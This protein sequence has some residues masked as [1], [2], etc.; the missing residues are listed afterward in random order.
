MDTLQR[1]NIKSIGELWE[2]SRVALQDIAAPAGLSLDD[3][4][5]DLSN[6]IIIIGLVLFLIFAHRRLLSGTICTFQA[7][8]GTKRL[9][10]IESQSNLQVCR[11]TLFQFLTVCTSF[12]FANIAYATGIIGHTH[13]LPV[14]FVIV[15]GT[16]IAFFSLRKIVLRLLAWIN[17][18]PIFKLADKISY[19]YACLWYIVVLCCFIVIKSISP[20]PMGLMRY[21]MIYSL[22]PVMTIYYFSI[23]KIFLSKGFSVF[24]YILYLCTL[25]ILP[26]VMLL[27]LNFS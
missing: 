11:N 3:P 1:D 9:M 16:I 20:A 8:S 14:R 23:F 5:R 17:R 2:G 6:F 27:Y 12:V 15:L 24:F 10:R 19:T 22:L 25:E 7:L 18:S 13:T 21:C 4:L 26:I